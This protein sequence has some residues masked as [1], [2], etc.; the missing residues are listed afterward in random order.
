MSPQRDT[1]QTR[2]TDR[3][4]TETA[5]QR[6]IGAYDSARDSARAAGRRV[7]DG[8]DDAPLLALAG[9]L[10]AGAVLASLLP[11]SRKEKEYLGPVAG[12]IKDQAGA[13]ASAARQ[14]GEQR[15]TELGLTREAGQDTLRSIF[16]GAGDAA[17]AGAQ[18]AVSNLRGERQS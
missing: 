3:S 8:F 16:E 5:R 10:A 13:A 18:A 15:L 6:A 7:G 4:L 2:R 17:K 12:R 11:V 1:N 9:G 14:A